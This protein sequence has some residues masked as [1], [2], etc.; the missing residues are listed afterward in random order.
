MIFQLIKFA[1]FLDSKGLAKEASEI[2]D[3]VQEFAE[4]SLYVTVGKDLTVGGVPGLWALKEVREL[5]KK[6]P[7][8][9]SNYGLIASPWPG[10]HQKIISLQELKSTVKE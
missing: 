3:I 4:G 5:I 2:D 8:F 1:D 9:D 7:E 6:H 10:E